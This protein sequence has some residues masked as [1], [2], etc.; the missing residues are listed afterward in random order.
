[1]DTMVLIKTINLVYSV[2]II[3]CIV[4]FLAIVAIVEVWYERYGRK[5]KA[6]RVEVGNISNLDIY[7]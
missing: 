1:M 4:L 2:V 3:A 5:A 7:Y 6:N